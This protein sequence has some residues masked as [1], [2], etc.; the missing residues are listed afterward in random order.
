M[1]DKTIVAIWGLICVS[2]PL[3]I[4]LIMGLN[5]TLLAV[6]IGAICTIVGY[7][8]GHKNTKGQTPS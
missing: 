5:G 2:A 7:V 1:D 6:C 8:F 4:A 3:C